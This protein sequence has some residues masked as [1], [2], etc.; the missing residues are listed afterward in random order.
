MASPLAGRRVGS[1]DCMGSDGPRR[2]NP[3]LSSRLFVVVYFCTRDVVVVCSRYI[4]CGYCWLYG[5]MFL[6]WC[7]LRAL[8]SLFAIFW[9]CRCGAPTESESV[10]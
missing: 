10:R 4:Y 6:G 5:T 2:C 7:A 3:T 9:E 8:R 1:L